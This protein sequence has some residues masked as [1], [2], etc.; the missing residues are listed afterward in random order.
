[1]PDRY[2]ITGLQLQLFKR[3][4]KKLKDLESLKLLREIEKQ[5]RIES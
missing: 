5:Q 1:M 3:M 2:Y 4:A